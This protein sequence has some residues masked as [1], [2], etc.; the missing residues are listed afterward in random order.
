[1]ATEQPD[2]VAV[3]EQFEKDRRYIESHWDELLDQRLGRWVV[4][5]GEELVGE[6]ATLPDALD[7]ARPK[8]AIGNAAVE[9]ITDEPRNMLL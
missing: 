8:C 6:G 7:A 5:Y 2:I 1:M 9:F 4:V 3:L